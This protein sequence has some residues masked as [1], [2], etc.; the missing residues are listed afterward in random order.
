MRATASPTACWCTLEL[1][2]LLTDANAS[3]LR[4]V[5]AHETEQLRGNAL[6]LG[7][8]WHDPGETDALADLAEVDTLAVAQR[9]DARGRT[10]FRDLG[11]PGSRLGVWLLAR[12]ITRTR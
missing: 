5:G 6:A 12:K 2:P 7:A 10:R 3:A 8:L 4:G 9:C 1:S 11:P